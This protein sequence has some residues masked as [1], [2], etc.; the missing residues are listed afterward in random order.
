MNAGTKRSY[1]LP[2]VPRRGDHYRI[3]I[4]G[5]GGCRVYSLAREYYIGSELQKH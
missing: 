3:K 1:Y 4:E 5:T 2:I